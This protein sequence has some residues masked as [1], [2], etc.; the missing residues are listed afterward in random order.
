MMFTPLT[1]MIISVVAMAG[2]AVGITISSP[3]GLP[4]SP[5]S[6]HFSSLRA[7]LRLRAYG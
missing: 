3:L 5:S 6:K 7:D 1:T 2:V 4:C